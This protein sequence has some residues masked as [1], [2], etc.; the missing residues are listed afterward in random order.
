MSW[1]DYTVTK[2]ETLFGPN[3]IKCQGDFR[4][5]DMS[6]TNAIIIPRGTEI[7]SLRGANLE[8]VDM[9]GV[10]LWGVD[11]T[12]ANLEK[13]GADITGTYGLCLG[14]SPYE[15]ARIEV[16]KRKITPYEFENLTNQD[17]FPFLYS[18]DDGD[19]ENRSP[20][21][22]R[23][24]RRYDLSCVDYS[25]EYLKS[26]VDEDYY[27]QWPHGISQGFEEYYMHGFDFSYTNI[28]ID[29]QEFTE[30]IIMNLEGVDLRDK[31]F[32]GKEKYFARC[33]L[34]GT[35]ASISPKINSTVSEY[36]VPSTGK[37]R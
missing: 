35:G 13:T 28:D 10:C 4:G 6:Y 34:K 12:D 32:K 14:V 9:R 30:E 26:E 16:S 17:A 8:G 11:I 31:N 1:V 2:K 23:I 5:V 21:E 25:F 7:Q 19:Y 20:Y 15:E 24:L 29:P 22:N 27:V 33:N 36:I 18:K 37:V 3:K